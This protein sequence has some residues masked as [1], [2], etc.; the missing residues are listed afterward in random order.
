MPDTHI[1]PHVLPKPTEGAVHPSQNS[2]PIIVA[3]IHGLPRSRPASAAGDNG[4]H[5]GEHYAIPAM[6][7][8][9][10]PI[11]ESKLPGNQI[12]GSVAEQGWC[13]GWFANRVA[14]EVDQGRASKAPDERKLSYNTK[15]RCRMLGDR[16][17]QGRLSYDKRDGKHQDS[18]LPQ[19][20]VP[21]GSQREDI[22]RRQARIGHDV[23]ERQSDVRAGTKGEQEADKP[24]RI[25]SVEERHRGKG[26][27]GKEG[28]Q[29][30]RADVLT[31]FR[32]RIR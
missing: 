5:D 31:G 10:S 4:G 1:D 12:P 23:Q 11:G 20:K 22:Q 16:E 24:V 13:D 2:L 26:L 25:L 32:L 7:E 27:R 15:A 30:D 3:S 19:E 29:P 14:V 28:H 18:V 17:Q 21:E 6:T 9:S 8:R